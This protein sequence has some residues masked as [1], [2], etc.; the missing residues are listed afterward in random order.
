MPDYSNQ[1]CVVCKKIFSEDD[2]IVVC[3]ECGAPYHRACYNETNSC[4]Y[5]PVHG[6]KDAYQ[7]PKNKTSNCETCTKKCPRCSSDNPNNANFCTKCGYIFVN[8]DEQQLYENLKNELPVIFDP[9]C[10]VNPNEDFDGVCAGDVAKF[11][12]NN[13]FYYM[14]VFKKEKFFNVSKFNFG[15]FW[16]SGLWFLYRKMY[17]KGAIVTIISFLLSVFSVLAENYF[18]KTTLKTLLNSS[19]ITLAANSGVDIYAKILPQIFN[20]PFSQILLFS[21]PY[22]F[23]FIKF[24]IMLFSGA[25]ANGIYYEH[26]TKKLKALKNQNL[27]EDVYKEKIQ[28]NGGIN[29]KLVL[30]ISLLFTIAKFLQVLYIN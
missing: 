21:L 16:F 12:G 1:K 10:G 27:S 6:T 20:L 8:L 17:K 3:P 29:L 7:A 13:T 15:A 23:T 25:L 19:E 18:A 30:T 24:F 28:K 9:M 4:I 26:C 14:N 2:D 5:A 11:V 22:L